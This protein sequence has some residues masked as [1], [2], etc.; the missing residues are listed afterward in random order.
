M[1]L[2]VHLVRQ[3]NIIRNI[4]FGNI[5]KSL[6]RGPRFKKIYFENLFSILL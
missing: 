6:S 1:I 3:R 2:W 4:Y 5:D